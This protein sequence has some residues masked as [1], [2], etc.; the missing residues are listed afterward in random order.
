MDRFSVLSLLTFPETQELLLLSA[1]LSRWRCLGGG[2]P[3]VPLNPP[4]VLAERRHVPGSARAT[5]S[6]VSNPRRSL[7]RIR[8]SNKARISVSSC[9]E[10][11]FARRSHVNFSKQN[12][13]RPSIP[14]R[15]H[16]STSQRRAGQSKLSWPPSEVFRA[17]RLALKH[18]IMAA[19]VTACVHHCPGH[20]ASVSSSSLRRRPRGFPLLPET[21]S[22]QAASSRASVSRPKVRRRWAVRS[23]QACRFLYR[24]R[25]GSE[26]V[27]EAGEAQRNEPHSYSSSRRRR[28]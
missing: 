22:A 4:R 18:A 20:P 6:T 27:E 11:A 7:W 13:G 19:K 9:G 21:S 28:W 12:P 17:T 5:S 14:S 3:P 10:I 16:T 8:R 25:G 23:S 1:C 24:A 15:W 2:S 26:W